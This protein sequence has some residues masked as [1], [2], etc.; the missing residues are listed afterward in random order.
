MHVMGYSGSAGAEDSL[1]SSV[2]PDEFRRKPVNFISDEVIS[3]AC[4]RVLAAGRK[5]PDDMIQVHPDSTF[6]AAVETGLNI[7]KYLVAT[8]NGIAH[9]HTSMLADKQTR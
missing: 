2:Q 9:T 1:E 7:V 3:D 8:S 6:D 5:P 4:R